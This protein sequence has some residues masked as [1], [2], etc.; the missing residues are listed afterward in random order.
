MCKH[1]DVAF[2][3]ASLY[4]GEAAPPARV[5]VQIP[6]S[7]LCFEQNSLTR[8]GVVVQPVRNAGLLPLVD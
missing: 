3:L 6:D 4:Q 7:R 5:R 2:L 1:S 8:G